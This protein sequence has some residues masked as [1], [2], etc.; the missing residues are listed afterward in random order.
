[1]K[2]IYV[3]PVCRAYN[4]EIESAILSGSYAKNDETEIDGGSF[5]TNKKGYDM[6]QD[7]DNESNYGTATGW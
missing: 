2:K 1:M 4:L 7:M 6:W 5:D 3:S